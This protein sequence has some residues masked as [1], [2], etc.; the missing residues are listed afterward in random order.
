MSVYRSRNQHAANFNGPVAQPNSQ[1][2][3]QLRNVG[4]VGFELA[5]KV[6]M[7][8]IDDVPTPNIGV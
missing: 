1:E 3:R 6:L 4:L 8:V 7:D 5:R 2:A